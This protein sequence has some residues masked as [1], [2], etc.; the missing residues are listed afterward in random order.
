MRIIKSDSSGIQV[1]QKLLKHIHANNT[2]LLVWQ[3]LPETGQRNITHSR[4]S[5]YHIEIGLL[6]FELLS[7]YNILSELPL[8]CYSEEDQFIFKTD[9]RETTI[10]ALT[11]GLP[12]EIQL[13]DEPDVTVIR[14]AGVSIST[15]WKTKRFQMGPEN[16]N[17]Y[18]KVKSM[19]ERS[20]RDQEFLNNEFNSVSL[21]E[22]D[23]MFADKRET[24]RAKPKSDKWVKVSSDTSEG[25]HTLKLYDLSQGGMSF[26]TRDSHFFPKGAKVKVFGFDQFNLDDPLIAQVMSHRP[27]DDKESEFKIGCKFDEGQD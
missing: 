5:S 8:Y 9:V 7:E 23:K 26:I 3:V 15:K 2:Q 19:A 17:D 22:E 21:D 18:M 25:T 20:S 6:K 16:Y 27:V 12:L 14:G 13:L 24:P 4:L 1:Y 10:K 11:V